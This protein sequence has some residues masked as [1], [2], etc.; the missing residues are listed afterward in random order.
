MWACMLADA[1]HRSSHARGRTAHSRLSE[2]FV[3]VEP[4]G[5][6]GTRTHANQQD[7][8]CTAA[9]KHW[10]GQQR[11]GT[12]RVS[13]VGGAGARHALRPWRA[14]TTPL[15]Q[16]PV[17]GAGRAYTAAVAASGHPAAQHAPEPCVA[18]CRRERHGA[19]GSLTRTHQSGVNLVAAPSI[20]SHTPQSSTLNH[21]GRAPRDKGR[22]WVVGMG[23]I[24][25]SDPNYAATPCMTPGHG[26]GASAYQRQCRWRGPQR[27]TRAWPPTPQPH[28]SQATTPLCTMGVEA[29]T[30]CVSGTRCG[31]ARRRR[32]SLTA[33]Q[34]P[35]PPPLRPHG[36]SPP[37]AGLTLARS[38]HCSPANV[39]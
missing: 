1:T 20:A 3:P 35:P 13:H 6:Q 33:P 7:M 17:G 8:C 9:R 5:Q 31:P 23:C 18:G 28:Q 39:G 2:T 14:G 19:Q 29:E 21:C 38:Y 22:V 24:C 12:T 36:E 16:S 32:L 11:A 10:W 15:G 27:R 26:R 37:A 4:L 34:P 30:K 25:I